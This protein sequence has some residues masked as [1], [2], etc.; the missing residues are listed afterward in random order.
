MWGYRSAAAA[1]GWGGC[2]RQ[3]ASQLTS[4][5]GRAA[6]AG[7]TAAIYGDATRA[8]GSA[9]VYSPLGDAN[10]HDAI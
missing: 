7:R 9:V 1:A 5:Q 4:S 6:G 2:L 10:K 3:A 8:L